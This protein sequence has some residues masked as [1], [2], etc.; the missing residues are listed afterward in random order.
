MAK[1]IVLIDIPKMSY[2]ELQKQVVT[3]EQEGFYF[4]GSKVA[5]PLG[6]LEKAINNPEFAV[7]DVIGVRP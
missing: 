6:E 7:F 5:I 1:I 4:E 2:E 3:R